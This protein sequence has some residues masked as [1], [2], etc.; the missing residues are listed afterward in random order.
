MRC[1]DVVPPNG[2]ARHRFTQPRAEV[3]PPEES[4]PG[5]DK[6]LVQSLRMLIAG[7]S[8]FD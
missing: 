3:V 6:H 5:Y 7:A 8:G 2:S 4:R 1:G